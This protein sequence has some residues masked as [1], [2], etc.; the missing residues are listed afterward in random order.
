MRQNTDWKAKYQGA[1][2]ELDAKQSEWQSLEKILRKAVAGLSIA[3]RGLDNKLDKQL[4]LIQSL[5]QEKQ[6]HKLSNALEG[7]SQVVTSVTNNSDVPYVANKFPV[8]TYNL[9]LGVP[10][11]KLRVIGTAK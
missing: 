4:E 10:K 6:D 3:G 1:I 2:K 8:A 7:L 9:D 5:S 11:N